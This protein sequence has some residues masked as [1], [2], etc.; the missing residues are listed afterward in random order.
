[1]RQFTSALELKPLAVMSTPTFQGARFDAQFLADMPA[2]IVDRAA[3]DFQFGS[4]SLAADSAG[5]QPADFQ[6]PIGEA[7]DRLRKWTTNAD[8]SHLSDSG[9]IKPDSP[10]PAGSVSHVDNLRFVGFD[11][12]ED[13]G[14][15]GVNVAARE[16]VPR[17]TPDQF[18]S[19]IGRE[20]PR[21]PKHVA[22]GIVENQEAVNWRARDL[23]HDRLTRGGFV[24]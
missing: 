12:S 17:R 8:D 5:E 1:M 10:Q 9:R 24:S 15:A 3:S 21:K 4:D 20:R 18:W 19:V 23:L 14:L 16:G 7:Q 22:Q 2:V 6:F 11:A 13:C